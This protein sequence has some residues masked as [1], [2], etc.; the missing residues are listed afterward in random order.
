MPQGENVAYWGPSNTSN[1]GWAVAG[2][3]TLFDTANAFEGGDAGQHGGFND[4]FFESAGSDHR[5]G[6]HFG[7]A[8][9]SVHFVSEDIDSQ[10]YSY[11]G[12]INDGVGAS[13]P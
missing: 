9:G 8:D 2:L 1:D 12:S 7:M 3:S 11:L 13:V 4:K 10:L 5:N 6:A